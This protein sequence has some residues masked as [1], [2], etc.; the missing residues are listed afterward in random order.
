MRLAE[1]ICEGAIC[2]GMRATEGEDAIR[3]LLLK[4]VDCGKLDKALL[5]PMLEA[6]K[7][8]SRR[9]NLILT[10]QT[11]ENLA[12]GA[13]NLPYVDVIN[14]DNLN[15]YDLTTHDVLIATSAA[16]ARLE[17]VYA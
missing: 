7:A 6:L 16:I 10:E 8:E 14:C 17:E 1:L 11:N 3:E 12:L 9:G 13:R 15:V 2:I 4:L 5:E